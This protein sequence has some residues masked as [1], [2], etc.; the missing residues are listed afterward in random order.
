ML[1]VVAAVLVYALSQDKDQFVLDLARMVLSAAG[2]G[3]LGYAIGHRRGSK[4][5]PAVTDTE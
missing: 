2:G 4:T 1:L 5:E 3:G